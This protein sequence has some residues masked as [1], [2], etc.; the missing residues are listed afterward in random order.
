MYRDE[1]PVS[2][3]LFV[4]NSG[5]VI[6]EEPEDLVVV[7][8][9]GPLDYTYTPPVQPTPPPNPPTPEPLNFCVRKDSSCSSSSSKS[10]DSVRKISNDSGISET[11]NMDSVRD[12]GMDLIGEPRVGQPGKYCRVLAGQITRYICTHLC[13]G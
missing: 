12:I 3:C 4:E 2:W 11:P 1:L 7:A 6:K 10:D 9:E 8:P 5:L 13:F